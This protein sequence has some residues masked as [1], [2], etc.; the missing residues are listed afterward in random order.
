MRACA[1]H[2]LLCTCG[3]KAGVTDSH[4]CHSD[5]VDIPE[6][7]V[8]SRVHFGIGN[9][10]ATPGNHGR[11]SGI[12]ESQSHLHL[13]FRFARVVMH[14]LEVACVRAGLTHWFGVVPQTAVGLT[15]THATPASLI[16]RSCASIS[17]LPWV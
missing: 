1:T 15:L 17:E 2:P 13:G 10:P 3:L 7:R 4:A 12:R 11:R 16:S 6:L 14:F 8:Y 5:V 9:R